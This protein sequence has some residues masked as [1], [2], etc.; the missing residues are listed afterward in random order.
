[1][2]RRGALEFKR[3]GKKFLMGGEHF[4]EPVCGEGLIQGTGGG[5]YAQR[6]IVVLQV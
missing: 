4:E 1:M 2:E 5:V 3:W 6:Y